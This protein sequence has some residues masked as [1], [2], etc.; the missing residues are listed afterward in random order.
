MQVIE[1]TEK[2]VQVKFF[3]KKDVQ[4]EELYNYVKTSFE[5]VVNY[6]VVD[7]KVTNFGYFYTV[8]LQYNLQK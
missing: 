2:I 4:R 7:A 6:D 8:Q 1:I 3:S 5:G